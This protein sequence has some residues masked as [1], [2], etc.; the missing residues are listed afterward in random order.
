MESVLVATRPPAAAPPLAMPNVG[1]VQEVIAPDKNQSKLDLTTIARAFAYHKILAIDKVEA[2]EDVCTDTENDYDEFGSDDSEWSEFES[3][4]D[5]V[6]DGDGD[7]NNDDK[8][9]DDDNDD[10]DLDDDDD[11][12]DDVERHLVKT[13]FTSTLILAPPQSVQ[14]ANVCDN[15]RFRKGLWVSSKSKLI[16]AFT[17][18]EMGFL[19]QTTCIAREAQLY[20][21][22]N[23]ACAEM[24]KK[25]ETIAPGCKWTPFRDWALVAM[26]CQAAMDDTYKVSHAHT[27]LARGV[28]LICLALKKCL[29]KHHRGK[30]FLPFLDGDREYSHRIDLAT[31]SNLIYWMVRI[32][33]Q[34]GIGPRRFGRWDHQLLP[35]HVTLPSIETASEYVERMNICKNRLWNLVNVSARKQSDLPDIVSALIPYQENLRHSGH[36]FCT[37]NKC[38]WAQMDSTGVK[39]L[40]K[41]KPAEKD[42]AQS[43]GQEC[44]QLQ[45]PVE[46]LETALEM[47]KSTA[48][49]CKSTALSGPNDPYIAISHVWSDGTGVGVKNAGTVNKC[50]IRFFDGIAA[51]LKCKAVWWDAISIPKEPKARSKALNK[52]HGNYANA[53]F[54]VVHDTY[55]L[56]FPWKEDGSPCLALVLSTWFTRGWTALELFMSKKVIVLFKDP[57]TGAPIMK[58]LDDDILAKSPSVASCAHWLATRLIQ[59]LRRPIDNVGDL[60]AVLSPR[61]TSWVRDRTIISAL[62][63]G[64]PD[65]D[66]TTGESI[67]ATKVLEYLGKIPYTCLFH[68]KPTMRDRGEYSWCAATLDD[69]PVDISTDL[70]GSSGSK[71]NDYLEI[72]EAGAVEG[73]WRWRKLGKDDDKNL[74]PY[75]N[76]LAAVVKI[77]TALRRWKRCLLLRQPSDKAEL[78]GSLALLVVPIS[79]IRS[80]GILKCRYVGAVVESKTPAKPEEG[81]EDIRYSSQ[82]YAIRIGGKDS[83]ILGMLADEA[84]DLMDEYCW[85]DPNFAD[86]GDEE[87]IHGDQSP[88]WSS[89]P[90]VADAP[91][92]HLPQWF[93]NVRRAADEP[94]AELMASLSLEGAT[95]PTMEAKHLLFALKSKN[96]EAAR[97][98]VANGIELPSMSAEQ[99]L[100]KLGVQDHSDDI[101]ESVLCLKLLADI[102]AEAGNLQRAID[103]Y[104]GV[105]RSIEKT[106]DD[107]LG[108]DGLLR[109]CY[110]KYSLGKALLNHD[111]GYSSH[112]TEKVRQL[113]AGIMESFKQ[114]NVKWAEAEK[115]KQ[116]K[117]EGEGP[118]KPTEEFVPPPLKRSNTANRFEKVQ[119]NTEEKV[120]NNQMKSEQRWYRLGLNTAAELTLLETAAFD[121]KSA[122]AVYSLALNRFG[123][124]IDGNAGFEGLWE[125]RQRQI[126][127]DKKQADERSANLYH[128]A[129]KRF[130][131]MF[132]KEHILIAITSLHLGINYTLRAMFSQAEDHLKR[133]L[134]LFQVQLCCPEKHIHVEKHPIFGL[135]HYYLGLLC[136]AQGKFKQAQRHLE[137][138]QSVVSGWTGGSESRNAAAATLGLSATYAFGNA[139]LGRRRRDLDKAET[140]FQSMLP[141]LFDGDGSARLAFQAQLGLA[142]VLLARERTADAISSCERAIQSTFGPLDNL[143]DDLDV[144]EALAFLGGA[145]EENEN[146]HLAE[147]RFKRALDGFKALQ[148][149]KDPSYLQVA[150]QLGAIYGKRS[151]RDLA[152]AMLTEAYGGLAE[153]VG[154]YH[155]STLKASWQLGRLCLDMRDLPAASEACDRAYTGFRK[156]AAGK[157]TRPIAETAQTLGDVYF[158]QAKLSKAKDMYSA[159]FTAFKGM[160]TAGSTKSGE[161]K[162]TKA[163]TKDTTNTDSKEPP[164]TDKATLLASLEVA[165]VCALVRHIELAEKH[166]KIA[167][168][169]FSASK[170]PGVGSALA[171]LDAQLKL[172]I[173][174]REQKRLEESWELLNGTRHGLLSLL[175]R[176]QPEPK[177]KQVRVQILQTDLAR[178]EV[179]LDYKIKRDADQHKSV[180][181]TDCQS[182]EL[183]GMEAEDLHIPNIQTMIE[184]AQQGLLDLLGENDPLS[185][186]ATTV[187][188]DFYMNTKQDDDNNRST[189]ETSNSEALVLKVLDTYEKTLCIARGHPKKLRVIEMLIAYYTEKQQT[190]GLEKMKGQLWVDLKEAYGVDVAAVIM[191]LKNVRRPVRE[192]R[193]FY[194]DVDDDS[195]SD[196]DPDDDAEVAE[197]NDDEDDED[198]DLSSWDSDSSDANVDEEDGGGEDGDGEDSSEGEDSGRLQIQKKIPGLAKKAMMIMKEKAVEREED[199]GRLRMRGERISGWLRKR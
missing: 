29:H 196:S 146:Y 190:E 148:G 124:H 60:L 81:E 14:V 78:D 20:P 90:A 103:L 35:S 98:L 73:K 150:R 143:P 3:D 172:A 76:D 130:N 75:G 49:L 198:D 16:T 38:Q 175:S 116:A 101:L 65:C 132:H 128:R 138:T 109:L 108:A 176:E 43:P 54:T 113:F 117:V 105:I 112:T 157:E 166:F 114:R 58:D 193:E 129:L 106:P 141:G 165:K 189:L 152:R 180:E 80:E 79:L 192:D 136:I 55:L 94:P 154:R 97:Y 22:R 21:C 25:M 164:I 33:S 66:F 40:H 67:I 51:E 71:S 99:I 115:R 62:L 57:V 170:R 167:V 18:L 93:K 70:G 53:Q 61:S 156:I 17:R 26:S 15:S 139:E 31:V 126:F 89:E 42:E 102:L 161:D 137:K 12:D 63:A 92:D 19:S 183:P 52:M 41:C 5:D 158:E 155:P 151:D 191:D 87:S 56:K 10:Y 131:T 100:E 195:D 11:D 184:G 74:R 181:E 147:A 2:I 122:S 32:Q 47:G 177:I 123:S 134:E 144:C 85:P 160:A 24:R 110:A 179:L 182:G 187:L 149:D 69:M 46:L 4:D 30:L 82:P 28:A 171:G 140:S 121:L 153:T 95:P 59:R 45:Y 142:R 163:K 185:L 199:G 119:E 50:L 107:E 186:H 88:G 6:N 96:E 7:S 86:D 111:P 91:P 120:N 83:G 48:W 178:S 135:A 194:S 9:D 118:P 36:H 37:P 197:D 68:G 173:F 159:A 39:Q 188:G 44:K 23:T 72:D 169:G 64:V 133:A 127:N 1:V 84:E 13:T 125:R 174:Y 8:D 27:H 145:Y 34:L 77:E 104:E 162:G 168:D